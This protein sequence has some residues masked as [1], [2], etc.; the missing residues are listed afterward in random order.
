MRIFQFYDI[1]SERESEQAELAPDER[2]MTATASGGG[3]MSERES[4]QIE[5]VPD[6]RRMTAAASGGSIRE[7]EILWRQMQV[8]F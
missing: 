3:I 7:G 2:R 1:M 8:S 4:E 6:E 5:L